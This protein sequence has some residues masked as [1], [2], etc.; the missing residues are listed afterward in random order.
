MPHKHFSSSE[1]LWFLNRCK[2]HRPQQNATAL[3]NYRLQSKYMHHLYIQRETCN[4][5]NEVVHVHMCTCIYTQ[6]ELSHRCE[7]R[8]LVEEPKWSSSRS[9]FFV[10]RFL[11]GYGSIRM[12]PKCEVASET[13]LISRSLQSWYFNIYHPWC[14]ICLYIYIYLHIYTFLLSLSLSIYI[15]TYVPWYMHILP[16]MCVTYVFIYV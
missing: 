8:W 10:I 1:R 2:T 14:I 13:F 15:Y 6:Q 7:H 4:Y 16:D 9:R 11:W 5:M 12:S 3:S